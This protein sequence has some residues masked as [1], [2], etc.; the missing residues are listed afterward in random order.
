MKFFIYFVV[1]S[2]SLYSVLNTN[3]N[4]QSSSGV[5]SQT[6]M[7]F[8]ATNAVPQSTK[9]MESIY[10]S[11]PVPVKTR[12][13]GEGTN[14]EKTMIFSSGDLSLLG[15]SEP[16]LGLRFKQSEED[17][18]NMVAPEIRRRKINKEIKDINRNNQENFLQIENNFLLEDKLLKSFKNTLDRYISPKE[19]EIVTVTSVDHITVS[20]N[21]QRN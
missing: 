13:V 18:K 14:F 15:K 19:T 8:S 11:R 16:E 5:S 6:E 1:F 7:T 12:M 20:N 3:L 10:E 9:L 2:F 17:V 21:V 4:S